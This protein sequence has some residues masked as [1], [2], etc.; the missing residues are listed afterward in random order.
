MAAFAEKTIVFLVLKSSERNRERRLP[1]N[2]AIP[3]IDTLTAEG[4]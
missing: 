3:R 2:F 1:R 4:L